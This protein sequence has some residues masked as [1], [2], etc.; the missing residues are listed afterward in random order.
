M[1]GTIYYKLDAV[2]VFE[3]AGAEQAGI[4]GAAYRFLDPLVFLP[5]AIVS[6]FVP[7]F[8]A[9]H[10]SDPDRMRRLVQRCAEL[11]AVL[12]VPAV[13][14]SVVL[15][16][17]V[18]QLLFGADYA[19][20]ASV[21]PVLMIAFASI[22]FGNLGGYLAPVVGMRWRIAQIALVGAVVNVTLNFVFVPEHGALAAAW[23][24][25]VTEILTMSMLMTFA[26]RRLGVRPS[27]RRPAGAVAAGV[28]MTGVLA[29]TE[30]L[31]LLPALLAGGLAY[32]AA[33]LGLRV[34]DVAELRS[35][36]A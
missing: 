7:V 1:L 34:I 18:V 22:C 17:Q 5:A 35:L 4:Y 12:A 32:G 26:L 9:T 25:V 16:P 33:V 28:V 8:A 15:S 19:A 6:A 29:L 20:S 14:V 13:A 21:L 11:L 30:P 36:R 24:T 3:L 23:A 2:L 31:G 27:L 10:G